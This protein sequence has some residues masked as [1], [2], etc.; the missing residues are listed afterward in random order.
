MKEYI[1]I[2]LLSAVPAILL[3]A[4]RAGYVSGFVDSH[5]WLPVNVTKA[6]FEFF[7]FLI[8]IIVSSTVIPYQLVKAKQEIKEKDKLLVDLVAFNK[9]NFVSSIKTVI[10]KPTKD[11]RTRLFVPEK[12]T[13]WQKV[14]KKS[15]FFVLKEINGLSDPLNAK[16]LRFEVSPLV[17]GVI[18]SVYL[19]RGIVTYNA[20]NNSVSSYLLN[21]YQKLHTADVK[22]ICAGPIFNKKNEIVAVLAVDSNGDCTM[23]ANA[24]SDCELLM[25]SYCSFVGVNVNL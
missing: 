21:D 4:G 11:L 3:F 5:G 25:A 20:V 16:H 19:T 8:G 24:L 13:L 2:I 22:F 18:G 17:E 9:S 23:N 1:K 12:R 15:K 7:C 10:K 14:S 6:E